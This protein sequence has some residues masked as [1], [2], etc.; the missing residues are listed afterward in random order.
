LVILDMQRYFTEP[1][2]AFAKVASSIVEGGVDQYFNT[3]DQAVIPNI[4]ALLSVFRQ[5]AWSVLYTEFGSYLSDGADMPS[6]ARRLND[7]SRTTFGNPMFP[8]FEAASARI[9]E[10]IKPQQGEAV[11]R[12][13]TTGAVTSSSLEQHLRARGITHV[14]IT[15]VVTAFCVS[16]TARELADR[17]FDVAIIGDGCASFTEA[18]HAAALTAFGGAYGWV[19]STAQVIQ[20]LTANQDAR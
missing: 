18:G 10:R 16:Q 7:F 20:V 3:V 1:S 14:I 15:G 4:Q 9:D 2:H 17:D 8:S 6:W 19:L 13:T 5:G 11:L 12:K